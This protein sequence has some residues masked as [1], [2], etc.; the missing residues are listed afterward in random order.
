LSKASAAADR[1]AKTVWK[2]FAQMDTRT[3]PREAQRDC[4]TPRLI[5]FGIG[6]SPAASAPRMDP[7][8]SAC[9]SPPSAPLSMAHP[10][11]QEQ[12]STGKILACADALGTGHA[13]PEKNHGEVRAQLRRARGGVRREHE[14]GG[15]ERQWRT[16][17]YRS[18]LRLS[19]S[20]LSVTETSR[21]EI[22]FTPPHIKLATDSHHHPP[23]IPRHA[24]SFPH[25]S[26]ATRCRESACFH[27]KSRGAPSFLLFLSSPPPDW[28]RASSLRLGAI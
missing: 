21:S 22:F 4:T 27:P 20:T 10:L 19:A 12:C 8:T 6:L 18:S 3:A 9:G 13:R 26:F 1:R 2:M 14:G 11:L 25:V 28:R 17:I 7:N 15:F 24:T 5:G 23:S 16:S